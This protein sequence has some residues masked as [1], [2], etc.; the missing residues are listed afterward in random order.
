MKVNTQYDPNYS[1]VGESAARIS[2]RD[3]Y[4]STNVI[5]D[6]RDIAAE[7]IE[8]TASFDSNYASEYERHLLVRMANI[9]E[10]ATITGRG[11]PHSIDPNNPDWEDI[12]SISKAWIEYLLWV[13]TAQRFL[14][15][16]WRLEKA[17]MG[18]PY[19][20]LFCVSQECLDSRATSGERVPESWAWIAPIYDQSHRNN[21]QD[22]SMGPPDAKEW[23]SAW[24][25]DYWMLMLKSPTGELAYGTN[26]PDLHATAYSRFS[27]EGAGDTN[28]IENE[29]P[30]WSKWEGI[31]ASTVDIPPQ[32]VGPAMLFYAPDQSRIHSQIVINLYEVN[33]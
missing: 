3:L 32:V 8:C 14:E 26:A 7:A 28:K 11:L 2:P 23:A 10:D 24:F 22:L 30:V 18:T 16:T 1:I 15:I 12:S 20:D 9:D 33:I 31:A 5:L 27:V 25:Q 4:L 29:S 19:E 21:F 17:S 13:P 6:L